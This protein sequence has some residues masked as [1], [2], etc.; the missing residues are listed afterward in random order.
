MPSPAVHSPVS[1]ACPQVPSWA[2]NLAP[3]ITA[4]RAVPLVEGRRASLECACGDGVGLVTAVVPGANSLSAE[5]VRSAV[6]AVFGLVLGGLRDAGVAHPV[7]MW[8]FVP[9]IHDPIAAGLDRYRVFN[10]GRHDAFTRWLGGPESFG[11]VLPAASAVGHDEDHLVVSALGVASPGAPV[12]NPRQT[13]AFGYSKVY[14]PVPPCFSRAMAAHLPVGARLLVSGTASIRGE[15]S[16]HPG[17]L[18]DQVAETF[19]NLRHLAQS[20]RGADRF[21]YEHI[22]TARVYYPRAEDRAALE[23]CVRSRWPRPASVEF[24]PAWVC[25]AE[26]LVEIEATLAPI[27]RE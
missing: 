16:V 2:R 17:S 11:R 26:L 7:R 13:P 21:S 6:S 19:E 25:R 15:D 12:E 1:A 3:R 4:T 22:E 14:G 27:P 9:G 20:V 24:V 23:S 10:A 5:G 18:A 8:S